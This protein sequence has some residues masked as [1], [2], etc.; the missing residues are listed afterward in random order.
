MYVHENDTVTLSCSLDVAVWWGPSNLT[1]YV[2]GIELDPR[3]SKY[4]RLTFSYN[5]TTNTSELQ[6]HEFSKED[7]G[8]Y[9]CSYLENGKLESIEETVLIKSK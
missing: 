9:R 7:E 1:T 3:L 8:L 4:N 2:S 6:I 5:Q